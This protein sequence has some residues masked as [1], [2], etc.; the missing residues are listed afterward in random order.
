M[1]SLSGRLGPE[2][3]NDFSGWA[4]PGRAGPE[5]I[6]PGRAGSR[7]LCPCAALISNARTKCLKKLIRTKILVLLTWQTDGKRLC[8][9]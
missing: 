7:D 4:G 5:F 2:N 6:K 9:N 1:F 8:S 3:L